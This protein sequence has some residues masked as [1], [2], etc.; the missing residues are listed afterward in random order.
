M[1]YSMEH[2]VNYDPKPTEDYT[3]SE[4]V[5]IHTANNL[6]YKKVFGSK[7][8]PMYDRTWVLPLD[9]G[10]VAL[11]RPVRTGNLVL[12]IGQTLSKGPPTLFKVGDIVKLKTGSQPIEVTAISPFYL[13]GKYQKSSYEIGPRKITDFELFNEG[14][15]N[16]NSTQLFQINLADSVQYGHYLATNS[17]GQYVMEVKGTGAI[18]TVP[19]DSIEEVLPYTISVVF[20]GDAPKYSFFAEA[21]KF[22]KG[23]YL[24]GDDYSNRFVVVTDLDTKSKKATKDFSPVAKVALEKL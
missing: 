8:N 21:G 7:F 24:M 18:V 11:P 5:Y 20:M 13:K 9:A 4:E 16:M 10:Y 15:T 6:K 2:G 23:V 19:K 1:A 22:E 14:T 3:L 12:Y 17:S